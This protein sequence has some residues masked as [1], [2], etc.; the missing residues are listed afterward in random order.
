MP[1]LL[2]ACALG[3]AVLIA[4]IWHLVPAHAAIETHGPTNPTPPVTDERRALEAQQVDDRRTILEA[5]RAKLKHSV[6]LPATGGYRPAQPAPVHYSGTIQQIIQQAFAPLGSGAVTWAERVALCE[7]GDNPNAVN[8]SSG[9]EGLFQIMPSTWAGTPY[10]SQS[11]F[12]PVA[13]A[14]AAAW[15]YARRGGSA[16]TC[17]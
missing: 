16:W 1:Q 7:S 6:A 2:R 10:A 15:I 3:F 14:R 12:D 9:A 11:E 17:A 5:K 8:R 13:N 4:Q